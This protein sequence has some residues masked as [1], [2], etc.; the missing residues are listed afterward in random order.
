MIYKIGL[1]NVAYLLRKV[2]IGT[3]TMSAA[4][5][6]SRRQMWVR[7]PLVSSSR[8]SSTSSTSW[9]DWRVV[10]TRSDTSLVVRLSL[11]V[12]EGGSALPSSFRTPSSTSLVQIRLYLCT[13]YIV[14]FLAQ[15]TL[16]R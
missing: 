8:E 11:S 1:K 10:A 5:S 4:L 2:A 3:A 13:M 14:H 9:P 16:L 7:I 15:N 6:E 12:R